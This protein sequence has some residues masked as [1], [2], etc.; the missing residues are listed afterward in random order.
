MKYFFTAVCLSL[1]YAS[2]YCSAE[3]ESQEEFFTAFA[4]YQCTT[5]ASEAIAL[6]EKYTNALSAEVRIPA[7]LACGDAYSVRGS[8]ADAHSAYL[9]AISDHRDSEY[10]IRRLYQIPWTKS[11][12]EK[13]I[14]VLENN[15]K[16][17]TNAY[18]HTLIRLHLAQCYLARHRVTDATR[19]A[20][21]AGC[22][23]NWLMAGGFDNAERT[24]LHQ[25][26]GPED[27]LLRSATYKGK[28]WDVSWRNAAPVNP[29]CSISLSLVQPAQWISVYMRTG[30]ISDRKT[31]AVLNLTIPTAFRVW[32]NGMPIGQ[33]DEYRYKAIGA[34]RIPIT[35]DPGTNTV[36][37]KI[38]LEDNG[39][40]FNCFL[41]TP[42]GAPLNLPTVI[43]DTPED[44]CAETLMWVPTQPSPGVHYWQ[45]QAEITTQLYARVMYARYLRLIRRYND[46]ISTLS[47]LLEEE[48]GSAFDAYML[49]RSQSY[50]DADSEAIASYRKAL[51]KDT[52]AVAAETLI[53]SHY[54]RRGHDELAQPMAEE[55]VK[56]A[57]YYLSAHLGLVDILLSRGWDEDAWRAVLTACKIAPDSPHA[58]DKRADVAY[59]KGYTSLRLDALTETLDYDASMMSAMYQ[60]AHLLRN[61]QQYDA[62]LEQIRKIQQYTP[63]DPDAYGM[64]IR[65]YMVQRDITNAIRSCKKA[66]AMFPDFEDFYRILGDLYYM[67]ENTADAITA[68]K[69]CLL[70]GP[71]NLQLRRYLEY[72]EGEDGHFFA[73]HKWPQEKIEELINEH[74]DIPQASDEE[75]LRF[76][77]KQTLVKLNKDGSSRI[78]GHIIMK[79]QSPMAVKAA[80]SAYI[81][82][83][84]MKAYT[85]KQDGQ[86][87]EAT[88][89]TA[90]QLEFPNV[91]VGD[92]LEYSYRYDRYGGSWL[93][94]N[95]SSQ[96][97]FNQRYCSFINNE[98]I[99]SVPTNRTLC[100]HV[101]GRDIMKSDSPVDGVNIY[102][103]SVTNMPIY[104]EEPHEPPFIDIAQHV[105]V[106]TITNW[107]KVADWQRGML[108]DVVR[109]NNASKTVAIEAVGDATTVTG[110]VQKLFRYITDNFR[111]TQL[112]ENRIAGVKPHP[113]PDI[114]ANQCGDC[115]DL[116]L[117]L[118]D[119]LDALGIN[120]HMAL[121]RSSMNGQI[122]VDVPSPDVFNH[123][124]VYIPEIGGN[125]LFVD[126]T[127]RYGEYDLMPEPCQDVMAFVI[128][129]DGYEFIRTPLSGP[130]KNTSQTHISGVLNSEGEMTGAV[131]IAEGHMQAA[132]LRSQ[133]EAMPNIRNNLGSFV[134]S[135]LF[136]GSELQEFSLTGREPGAEPLYIDFTFTA[137]KAAQ[138]SADGLTYQLPFYTDAYTEWT[139]LEERKHPLQI[140]SCAYSIDTLQITLPEG[141][142]ADVPQPSVTYSNQFGAFTLTSET[143]AG[144]LSVSSKFIINQRDISVEE[145]P[146]FR[147]FITSSVRAINQVV[148]IRPKR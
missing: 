96:F 101:H 68:Y 93:D 28:E 100:S 133:I 138:K 52:Q 136:P 132:N 91:Q 4:Q 15:L 102:T 21:S 83:E 126:P 147:E 25:K 76:L 13:E 141:Y 39:D 3:Q 123:V 31:D 55:L 103:W 8:D 61:L 120:S 63:A 106:S 108:S 131:H 105:N 51:E 95:Y 140:D 26:F 20:A 125:G 72:I 121:I 46:A 62:A 67:Q 70:Y 88:H 22:L 30:I 10:A 124:V 145:Y 115:K 118:S 27:D 18:I 148:S 24:G 6:M 64:E 23:T 112:Y 130:E 94:E 85:W 66:I 5:N 42:E 87:L 109:G 49:G 98:V 16:I 33:N 53:A 86:K 44:T 79:V 92:T 97:V 128:T 65:V 35:L 110:K 69:T 137:P 47:S 84:L 60:R 142:V 38:C 41:T 119:M 134:L 81:P 139:M 48:C 14:S 117:L 146:A 114:L 29:D 34:D 57:P 129:D 99:L 116:S 111:Y 73:Q 50:K 40:H 37:I 90:G 2:L 12:L 127:F 75:L 7:L 143:E 43:E 58:Q 1:L 107:N 17:I 74:K 104:Q 45:Q 144:A 80:S 36:V 135:S 77:L 9:S 113:V 32:L 82:G 54:S 56:K 78:Q 19:S 122:D 11:R 71:G 59:D 89:M